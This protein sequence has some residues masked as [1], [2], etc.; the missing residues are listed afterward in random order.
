MKKRLIPILIFLIIFNLSGCGDTNVSDTSGD[1]KVLLQAIDLLSKA[2]S[3]ELTESR[4]E[5][6]TFGDKQYI[7]QRTSITEEKIIV[8]PFVRWGRSDSTS[9]KIYLGG[10]QR[11]LRE[12]YQV[13][14]NGQLDVYVRYSP[15][16]DAAIGK[17]PVLGEWE[18]IPTFTKEQDAWTLDA[19]RNN[20]DAQLYLLSSN[21]DTFKKVEHY[22]VKDENIIKYEG[23]LEQTT[24]L[25]AYQ[26][27][28]RDFWVKANLLK[29]SKN[30][31]LEDLKNEIIDGG[32]LEIQVGIPM[33]AY[34]DE[35]VPISLWI[36]KNTFKLIK[37]TVDETL[38]MQ[39]YNE[40]EVLKNNPELGKPIVSEALLTYEIKSINNL[41][42]IPMPD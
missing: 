40:K 29:D 35:P 32:V 13:L 1:D 9:S 19:M 34:S 38:V 5:S 14:N 31:S 42:E 22:E 33:L 28:I 30:L 24:I 7:S 17:E 21:I 4:V 16:Q 25:E 15:T 12:S 27:Y 11:S 39:S 41:N 26:K 18:K 10:Q 8:E 20:F 37:V 36:D 23:Y 2:N 6:T 3:Y